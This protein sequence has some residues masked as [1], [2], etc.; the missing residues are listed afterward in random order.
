M[1][2]GA[3][4]HKILPCPPYRHLA[5]QPRKVLLALLS[6][7]DGFWLLITWSGWME[8]VHILSKQHKQD[9]AFMRLATAPSSSRSSLSCA[10][11]ALRWLPASL[12]AAAA[13]EPAQEVVYKQQ[14]ENSEAEWKRGEERDDCSF[15]LNF[16]DLPSSHSSMSTL[17][18]CISQQQ[19]LFSNKDLWHWKRLKTNL[20]SQQ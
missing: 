7:V 16:H 14:R 10:W 15:K 1:G 17:N 2:F 13:Q 6:S 20:C 5:K 3:L 12:R 9:A 8:L 11:A 19:G 4:L 18:S